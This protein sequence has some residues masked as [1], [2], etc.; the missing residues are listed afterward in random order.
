V[1]T[2]KGT[3]DLAERMA[4]VFHRLVLSGS[5]SAGQL[6]LVDA[7][8]ITA[9]DKCESSED[10]KHYTHRALD[11]IVDSFIAQI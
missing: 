10:G 3:D 4:R 6:G 11:L 5:V 8:R 1:F 7:N 2:K 9:E